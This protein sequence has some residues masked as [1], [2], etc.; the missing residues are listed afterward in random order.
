MKKNI[1]F[2]RLKA[3]LIR[4]FVYNLQTVRG[5]CQVQFYDFVAP[6]V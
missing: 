4:N 1:T 3:S 6:S 2:C 5:F